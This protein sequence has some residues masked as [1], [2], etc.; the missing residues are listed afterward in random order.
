MVHSEINVTPLVDVCLVLLIIFMVVTPVLVTGSPVQLPETKHSPALGEAPVSV[1]VMHDGTVL[2]GTTVVR[3]DQV[4]AELQ[5]V[6][7]TTHSES[8][9]VRGDKQAL[10]GAVVKVLDACRAAGW[11]DVKLVSLRAAS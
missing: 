1:T 3:E 10:Y 7:A 6:R 2:I 8:I 9:A 11:E 5:R 4:A